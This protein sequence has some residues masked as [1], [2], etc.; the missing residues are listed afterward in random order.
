MNAVRRLRRGAG[1]GSAR[2]DRTDTAM[3]EVAEKE[4]NK[5]GLGAVAGENIREAPDTRLQPHSARCFDP[6]GLARRGSAQGQRRSAEQS[7]IP[8][9]T[10]ELLDQAD[11]S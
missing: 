8:S 9:S 10:I 2:G 4:G 3:P 5:G 11:T 1:G 7:N 6:S